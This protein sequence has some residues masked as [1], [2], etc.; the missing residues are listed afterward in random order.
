M[1]RRSETD[2]DL[3]VRFGPQVR[4]Q[5]RAETGCRRYFKVSGGRGTCGQCGTHYVQT[6]ETGLFTAAWT[7]QRE[8][9]PA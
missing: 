4:Y 3:A 6:P 1:D 7:P 2:L 8:S 5:C 9:V